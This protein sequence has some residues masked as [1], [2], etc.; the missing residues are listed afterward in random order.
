MKLKGFLI[1]GV[2]YLVSEAEIE[3]SRRFGRS[4]KISKGKIAKK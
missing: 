4:G 3:K 1:E 2:T